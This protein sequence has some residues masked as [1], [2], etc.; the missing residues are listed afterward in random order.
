MKHESESSV[1]SE[2]YQRSVADFLKF[3]GSK[4]DNLAALL[5]EVNKVWCQYGSGLLE[6]EILHLLPVERIV[7]C[8]SSRL[9][10]DTSLDMP[11]SQYKKLMEAIAKRVTHTEF[12]SLFHDAVMANTTQITGCQ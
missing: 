6:E 11:V 2:T 10:S 7:Q 8:V 12:V 9:A 3:T 1:S 5:K 4:R